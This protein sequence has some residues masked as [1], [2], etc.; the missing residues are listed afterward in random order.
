MLASPHSL[1]HQPA[2]AA[3]AS[4]PRHI[5][6]LFDQ[7]RNLDGGAE[8]SLLKTVQL[9][10]PGPLPGLDCYLLP[11]RG[12]ALPQSLSLSHPPAASAA[13][14]RLEQPEDGPSPPRHHPVRK[15]LGSADFFRFL[16]SAGRCRG[17]VERMPGSDLQ[18]PRYG[19][20]TR[21]ASIASATG[22]WLPLTIASTPSRMP[23]AN[24][25]FS[26]D[27]VDPEKVVTIPNGVDTERIAQH[28]DPEFRARHGLQDA[29]H[30]IVDVG[31]VKP[32]K[33]YQVLV[34]AAGLVCSQFPKAVFAI[35]GPVQNVPYFL[36]LHRLIRSLGLGKE[37]QVPGEHRPG[38][39]APACQR[40]LLSSLLDRRSLE[41]HAGSD[42][43]RVCLVSS[44]EW[45]ETPKWWRTGRARS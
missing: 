25:P 33:G 10:P 15:G 1:D 40:H 41:R 2:G 19:L 26:N 11:S 18:P 31:S 44:P 3:A 42:G 34:R 35:A 36:E 27:R 22:C 30:V 32:V 39:S 17:A 43:H 21:N 24:T 38:L 16:R 6:Y 5:L 9:L 23:F 7:L 45:A 29:S 14:L 8:R 13:G 28:F 4:A 20:S 37:R 12:R